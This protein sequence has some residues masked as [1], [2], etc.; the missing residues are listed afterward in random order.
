MTTVKA[1]NTSFDVEREVRMADNNRR[2]LY[3][4]N[5][6]RQDEWET[7]FVRHRDDQQYVVS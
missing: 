1:A 3:Q 5:N 7:S 4:Q 2:A 6:N